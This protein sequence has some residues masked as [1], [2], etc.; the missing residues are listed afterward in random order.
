[1]RG[2]L[3]G[4]LPGVIRSAAFGWPLPPG[5]P[6][7]RYHAPES[8]WPVCGAGGSEEPVLHVQKQLTL[9]TVC[10]STETEARM[11]VLASA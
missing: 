10:R 8:W 2:S 11:L 6:L 3:S 5:S 1:M 9:G 7:G 4:T